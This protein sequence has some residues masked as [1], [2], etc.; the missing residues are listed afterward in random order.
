MGL[1]VR[2]KRTSF[3]ILLVGEDEQQAFLHFAVVDNAVQFLAR[4][5]YP[6]AV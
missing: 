2:A 4:L 1:R 5:V 3:D 6:L